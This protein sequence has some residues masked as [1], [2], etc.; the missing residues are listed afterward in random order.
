MQR[1]IQVRFS[2]ILKNYFALVKPGIVFGNLITA[3]SGFILALAGPFSIFK[4]GSMLLGLSLVIASACTF[5]NYIDRF[6]DAKMQRTQG[7]PLVTGVISSP[8]ALFFAS[9]CA[10]FGFYLLYFLTSC[11]S[12][13]AALFG[14]VTYVFIYSLLKYH[15]PLCTL[16]GSFAGAIPTLVGYLA[17]SNTLDLKGFL[18]FLTILLWQMPHFYAISIYRLK[19]YA[20][21]NIPV[22]PVVKGVRATKTQMLFYTLAYLASAESLYLLGYLNSVFAL[23]MLALATLWLFLSYRGYSAKDD[24]AWARKMFIFSLIIVMTQSGLVCLC[25]A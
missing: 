16:L 14:F 24:K 21:G 19:D 7:R 11:Y 12:A 25:K 13:Y 15:S 17:L 6:L 23:I 2:E 9:I 8:K 22:L 10:L 20:L 3:F 4:L 1:A 5:N 18:I